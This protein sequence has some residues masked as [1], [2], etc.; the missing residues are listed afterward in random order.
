M[1]TL[2]GILFLSSA[3]FIMMSGASFAQ[4][5]VAWNGYLQTRFSDDF[6][7]NTGFSIRRAK[8]W[9]A[10]PTPVDSNL[11]FRMQGIFRYQT[12]GTFMLQDV[13]AQYRLPFGFVKGG[14]FVPDFSLERSQSDAYLPIIER[15]AVDNT[16]IPTAST[17]ARDIGAEFVLQP[18]GTGFHTSFGVYNGNGGNTKC[19]EDRRLL[20]TDR[21][22]Y[23]IRFSSE[24]SWTSGFSVAY[25]DKQGMSFP[26]ILGNGT[27]FTGKD[28]RW[29]LETHL[30]SEKWEIQGEYIQADLGNVK[31]YGYYVLGEYTY[32]AKNEITLS[33]E[34]LNVPIPACSNTPWYIIDY[35]HL[36]AGQKEKLIVD[37]RTQRANNRSSYE[38]TAQFQI[39]FN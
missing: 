12:S 8:M 7:S 15:A 24:L 29:G 38:A 35:S 5:K 23:E 3:L 27:T 18:T 16:L 36:F 19:N 30:Q 13:Y 10:G 1:K 4:P 17:Y 34:E 2:P 37:A 9:V 14:Q 11:S 26:A 22:T 33:T 20:Y 28:F 32:D 31:S 6:R 25:G 39:F 21:T